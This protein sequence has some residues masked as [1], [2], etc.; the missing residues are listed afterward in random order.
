[1]AEIY[2]FVGIGI[3]KTENINCCKYCKYRL[4]QPN[5]R[6]EIWCDFKNIIPIGHIRPHKNCSHYKWNIEV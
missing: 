3:I 1:M 2:K 5:K 4:T 6:G